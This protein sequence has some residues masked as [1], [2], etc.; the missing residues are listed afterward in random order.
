MKIRKISEEDIPALT[1]VYETCFPREK[2][3]KQWIEANFRS[4]PRIV[5]Y[6]VE[7]ESTIVGYIQW[8]VKSGFRDNSVVELEQLA[9]LPGHSGKGFGSKLIEQTFELFKEH[10]FD[11]GVGVKA[12]YVTTREGNFAEK[13][14]M[15]VLGVERSAII[16]EYGSGDEVV[17]FKRYV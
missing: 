10:L 14:Y 13:L 3:Q 6:I 4:F 7:I 17:L 1:D 11:L 12:V 9:V 5:Y 16:K 15:K 2:L 8:S